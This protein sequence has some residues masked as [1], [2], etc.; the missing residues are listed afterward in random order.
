MFPDLLHP[1]ARSPSPKAKQAAN[2]SLSLADAA[3]QSVDRRYDAKWTGKS[4]TEHLQDHCRKY[5]L[6]KPVFEK[7][8]LGV[9]HRVVGY[10]TGY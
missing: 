3:E 1:S 4:P 8:V 7:V 9:L 10:Y 6:V 2:D 5:K